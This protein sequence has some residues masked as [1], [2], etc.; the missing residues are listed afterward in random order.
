MHTR[1]TANPAPAPARPAIT[2]VET[3]IS[4]VLISGMLLIAISNVGSSAKA[5][6]VRRDA[7]SGIGIAQDLLAE[8]N[9]LP[10]SDTNQPPLWGPE[11]G[12]NTGNRAAFDD[13]D[14]Y[15]NW[16]ETP[17]TDRAGNPITGFTGWKRVVALDWMDP[18][19]LDTVAVANTGLLRITVSATSP[20][21]KVTTMQA[22]RAIGKKP[23]L[24]AGSVV[25]WLN[26][27]LTLGGNRPLTIRDGTHLVNKPQVP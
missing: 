6:G 26:I 12:E 8:I 16:S 7:R 13:V 21:G 4:I 25:G 23:P 1:R 19:N 24:E 18:L 22:L 2:L 11:A 10:A 5:W 17:P 14:D 9:R 3:V 15:H 20:N 27:E